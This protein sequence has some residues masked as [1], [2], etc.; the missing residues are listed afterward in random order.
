[1]LMTYLGD[2][3]RRKPDLPQVLSVYKRTVSTSTKFIGGADE[4]GI[5]R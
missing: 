4:Q 2:E 3:N 5:K 1:M